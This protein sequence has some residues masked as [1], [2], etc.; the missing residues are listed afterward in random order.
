HLRHAT[1]HVVDRIQTPEAATAKH[2]SLHGLNNVTDPSNVP[3]AKVLR[4]R[5]VGGPAADGVE[6]YLWS[7]TNC[8]APGT[9]KPPRDPQLQREPAPRRELKTLRAR[10]TRRK[11]NPR[12]GLEALR[13]RKPRR[14]KPSRR[15][16]SLATCCWPSRNCGPNRWPSSGTPW[17]PSSDVRRP[18]Y[19]RSCSQWI[20]RP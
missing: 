15:R 4:S 16:R 7:T 17:A 6:K 12:R 19:G 2:K 14:T 18:T 5:R 8:S 1:G 20:P 13:T 3:G 10:K 9:P 11:P